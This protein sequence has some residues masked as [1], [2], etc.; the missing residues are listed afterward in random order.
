MRVGIYNEPSGSVGGSEYVVSVLAHALS[1]RHDVEVIHHNRELTVDQLE[2]LSGLDMRNVRLRAA[3]RQDR[4]DLS[5]P[6]GLRNVWRRYD[7]QVSW[8]ADLSGPYDLFITSTHNLPPF[9]HAPTGVMLTLFPLPDRMSL[10]PWAEDA[11]SGDGTLKH[12]LRREYSDW[13]W[14]KRFDSY[15]YKLS[16]SE[17]VRKWTRAWWGIE[18]EI[19]YPPV[20]TRFER[21]PKANLVLSVGRFS[22]VSHSKR[23]VETMTVFRGMKRTSLH[24]W[25]YYSVGGLADR[26]ADHAYFG[27]VKRLATECG[28]RVL[29]NVPRGDLRALFAKAKIF[30][31][32]AGYGGDDTMNPFEAEHFGIATVEAMAAGIV[33]IVYDQGGQSE[34]VEHGRSG[35]LWREL[36]ELEEYTARLANDEQL[37][38]R[39]AAAAQ[40]RAQRFTREGFLN[41]FTRLV[42][43]V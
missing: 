25:C 3:P 8:H 5:Y 37:R 43:V 23:Q 21:A 6:S 28:A 16:I 34:I 40:L 14:Q 36:D 30:W 33:P 1:E 24:D 42:P 39:M 29:A 17:Y 19:L 18:T 12:R 7:T 31:H 26:P 20:D 35:Y 22:T 38:V 15:Q 13:L 32:A 27:A 9:C 11:S 4:P 10:W 2:E 41:D